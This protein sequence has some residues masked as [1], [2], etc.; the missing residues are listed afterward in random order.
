MKI[1]SFFSLC[2]LLNFI[3]AAEVEVSILKKWKA[4]STLDI[5]TKRKFVVKG[6]IELGSLW[7]DK[8]PEIL[9]KT[10]DRNDNIIQISDIYK[11][12]EDTT[13]FKVTVLGLKKFNSYRL[14]IRTEKQVEYFRQSYKDKEK[15]PKLEPLKLKKNDSYVK[16]KGKGKAVQAKKDKDCRLVGSIINKGS[17][18]AKGIKIK[19]SVLNGMGEKIKSIDI[20]LKDK[21]GNPIELDGGD[22]F[23]F[24]QL[25]EN[26]PAFAGAGFSLEWGGAAKEI[27]VDNGQ[28]SL[29]ESIFEFDND[30]KS[31][32]ITK[33]I[34]NMENKNDLKLKISLYNGLDESIFNPIIIIKLTNEK[35]DLIQPITLSFKGELS[36]KQNHEIPYLHKKAPAFSGIEQSLKYSIK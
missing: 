13:S 36:S 28:V 4:R 24:D 22:V 15:M 9:I 2:F 7:I 5:K 14:C 1:L 25:V 16:M 23:S 26:V 32:Q 33:I 19:A 29:K 6:T 35:G 21:E 3:S 8:N 34:A 10:L 12:T 20:E 11:V 30:K 27:L 17:H 31:A 18:R